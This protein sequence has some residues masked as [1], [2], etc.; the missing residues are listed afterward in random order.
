MVY[1]NPDPDAT[2]V[3]SR[4]CEEGCLCSY[5]SLEDGG[6]ED[7]GDHNDG[8][9]DHD[10]SHA[11]G[12]DGAEKEHIDEKGHGDHGDGDGDHDPGDYNGG[13]LKSWGSW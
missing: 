5:H 4:R 10:P 8:H 1:G 13:G 2:K 3:V 11:L 9:G 12:E 6:D 7:H